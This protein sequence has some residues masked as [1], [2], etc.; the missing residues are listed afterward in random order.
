MSNSDDEMK[1]I[2][3]REELKSKI[4]DGKQHLLLKSL[5]ALGIIILSRLVLDISLPFGLVGYAYFSYYTA[6]KIIIPVIRKIEFK[7]INTILNDKKNKFNKLNK[8]KEK[9]KSVIRNIKNKCNINKKK[10]AEL[11]ENFIEE[12]SELHNDVKL[13]LKCKIKST[14]QK[15]NN[16]FINKIHKFK[17]KMILDRSNFDSKIIVGEYHLKSN[18]IIQDDINLIQIKK[19]REFITL[20]KEKVKVKS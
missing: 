11:K 6:K 12:N 4:P 15:I 7:I 19:F 20:E 16:L 8:V 18:Q 9:T 5:K 3:K 2:S 14:S 13:D 17:N 10:D 1:L